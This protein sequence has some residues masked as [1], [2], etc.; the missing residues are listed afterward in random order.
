MQENSRKYEKRKLA[1]TEVLGPV[2]GELLEIIKSFESDQ[3]LYFLNAPNTSSMGDE[4][5][6][7]RNGYRFYLIPEKLRGQ[8]E[9][10][11]TELNELQ[12]GYV[13]TRI[14]TLAAKVCDSLLGGFKLSNSPN[15]VVEDKD[16]S[17]TQT[18]FWGLIFWKVEPTTQKPGKLREVKLETNSFDPSGIRLKPRIF[19]DKDAEAFAET[20]FKAMWEASDRDPLISKAR[21]MHSYLYSEARRLYEVIKTEIMKWAD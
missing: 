20:F 17:V 2:H 10:F 6:K 7:I 15:F 16:D 11:F 14:T 1:V 9:K 8:L 4:W 21:Q 12:P 18:W 13:S 3:K 19:V 5:Q